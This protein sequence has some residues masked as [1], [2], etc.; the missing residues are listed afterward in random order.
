M[1][2]KGKRK[3]KIGLLAIILVIFLAIALDV[4]NAFGTLLLV[5][6]SSI[7][8]ILC[9]CVLF[10]AFI[11]LRVNIFSNRIGIRLAMAVVI[12]I[13]PI[14]NILPEI[15]VFA[16]T[17]IHL[18]NRGIKE[19]NKKVVET[20]N[21]MQQTDAKNENIVRQKRV[22]EVQFQQVQAEQQKAALQ[23]ENPNI[24]RKKRSEPSDDLY[25]QERIDKSFA[26]EATK[27]E[28][29]EIQKV[30]FL[31]QIKPAKETPSNVVEFPRGLRADS[32][33]GALRGT[34][35]KYKEAA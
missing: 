35:E 12:G 27:K 20:E 3:E 21:N 9:Y 10:V 31:E 8:S 25:Q 7:I 30:R 17:T 13:I 1:E 2:Y 22:Q 6:G 14:L 23:N 33:K 11:I 24:L 15:T 18:V 26:N 32:G 16:A 29:E 28:A 4:I 34:A 5:F 19:R